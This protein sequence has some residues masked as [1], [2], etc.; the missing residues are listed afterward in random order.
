M[1]I[2][3]HNLST[4]DDVLPVEEEHT[5]LSVLPVHSSD[6]VPHLQLLS[7]DIKLHQ[8]FNDWNHLQ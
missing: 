7:A 8:T 5:H 4:C 2:N 3:I 1:N 6:S